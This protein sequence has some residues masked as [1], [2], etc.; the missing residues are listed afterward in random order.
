[1]DASDLNSVSTK[2]QALHLLRTGRLGNT[3]RVWQHLSDVEADGYQGTLS[4]RYAGA[5]GGMF[6][7]YNVAVHDVPAVLEK[8]TRQGADTQLV[9]YNESA[10]DEYLTLQGELMRNHLGLYLFGSTE[11]CKMRDALRNSGQHLWGLQAKLTLQRH[12]DPSSYDDLMDLLDTYP[13]HVVEFST[14][15]IDL[16]CAPHRNTVVWEVRDY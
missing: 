6:C 7:A 11:C 15:A 2:Q 14:Y 10:P 3:L 5:F 13:G 1:M 9:Q 12:V 8:W 4:L 16:G